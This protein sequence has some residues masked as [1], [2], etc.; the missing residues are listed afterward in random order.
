[1]GIF[2]IFRRKKVIEEVKT[3]WKIEELDGKIDENLKE[4]GDKSEKTKKD[5]GEIVRRFGVELKENIGELRKVNIDNRKEQ[6]KI[7][8]I[9]M[10]NFKDY[11]E[12]LEKLLEDL[13]KIERNSEDYIAQV[14]RIFDTFRKNSGKSYE[15][16]TIL[17]GR[18]FE[19]VQKLFKE[20]YESF[21]EILINN[22]GVFDKTGRLKELRTAKNVFDS[23]KKAKEELEKYRGEIEGKI[24]NLE[25]D[26][27]SL[28]NEEKKIKESSEFEE[29]VL[30][31]KKIE[32][33]RRELNK[34]ILR[35]KE[36]I[37]FKQLLKN[38]HSDEKKTK[39]LLDLQNNF[40]QSLE[41]RK[42]EIEEMVQSLGIDIKGDT[43]DILDR[44]KS[45]KI[46][47]IEVEEKLEDINR[48]IKE[49]SYKIL[50]LKEEFKDEKKKKERFAE[51]ERELLGEIRKKVE[52]IFGIELE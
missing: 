50:E 16:S 44:L 30:R 27:K 41:K 13:G 46:E 47:K 20:F 33:E 34:E 23:S 11:I 22:K 26:K 28:E 21:N 7:K 32:E 29:I 2:G 35:L 49:A 24:S 8:K 19:P 1:M 51:K 40:L 3:G 45:Q 52:D 39:V 4:L 31:N 5:I 6:E 42:F 43:N 38:F 10:E 15:K 9:V 36:K 14:R 17:I 12:Y 25:K 18:Q 48:R 37:N